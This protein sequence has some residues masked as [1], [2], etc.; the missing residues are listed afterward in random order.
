MTIF[1]A[2]IKI[3]EKHKV[4]LLINLGMLIFI[5]GINSKV[6]EVPTDFESI[7]PDILIINHD[8]GGALSED[9]IN[10]MYEYCDEGD[11]EK[12]EESIQD[13][14]FYRVV[15]YVMIIPEN[16]TEDFLNGKEPKIEI[17]STGDHYASIADMTLN[18][19]IHKAKVYLPISNS[20]E[21]LIKAIRDTMDIRSDVKFSDG[22]SRENY[23]IPAV[24]FNFLNFS[25]FSATIYSIGMVVASFREENVKKRTIVSST[26]YRKFNRELIISNGIFAIIIWAIYIL[27][28]FIFL[29]D[30]ILNIHGAM[31]ILNSFIF[32]LSAIGLAF[33]ITNLVNGKEGIN[34]LTNVIS[35][36]SSF[37]SGAFVPPFLLP[38]IALNISKITPSYWYI[39]SNMIIKDLN[40]FNSETLR[41]VFINM[42]IMIG[43]TVA[44]IV[45]SN[46]ISKKKQ[47]IE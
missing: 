9:L 45:I 23:D 39:N 7:R 30:M 18:K 1:K 35:L 4:M 28:G 44:F 12:E 36:G 14:F 22:E 15:Q 3:L 41:P 40:K 46:I 2:F 24:Y 17:K 38:D 31:F 33:L 27:L 37:L 6:Q 42:G 32:N 25:I 26:S 21:D 47:I 34:G 16:F 11:V 10:Y 29:K 8:E 13:A 5:S 43:F 19:Y 20:S